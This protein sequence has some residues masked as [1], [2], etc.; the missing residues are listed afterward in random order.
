VGDFLFSNPEIKGMAILIG[1]HPIIP[2]EKLNETINILIPVF[3]A[4]SS[5]LAEFV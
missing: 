4:V 1:R 3:P 2:L 5:I